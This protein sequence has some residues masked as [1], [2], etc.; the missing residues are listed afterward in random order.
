[1]D[2]SFWAKS[3]KRMLG[4]VLPEISIS[5]LVTAAGLTKAFPLCSAFIT[6]VPSLPSS[7]I[8]PCE[9]MVAGPDSTDR[10]TGTV[11]KWSGFDPMIQHLPLLQKGGSSLTF[12]ETPR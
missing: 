6:T 7:V 11:Y 4:L 2:L 1:M 8:M 10:T 9:S 12:S 3:L 5:S